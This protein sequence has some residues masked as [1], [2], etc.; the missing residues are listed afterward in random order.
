MAVSSLCSIWPLFG[1]VPGRHDRQ[2][3]GNRCSSI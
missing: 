3:P 2:P 1:L